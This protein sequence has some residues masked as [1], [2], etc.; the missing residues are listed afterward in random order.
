MKLNLGCHDRI[1]PGYI[2][3][4]RDKYD[5]V[6]VVAD[7]S[8]LPYKDGE[9]DEVYVSHIL[10]HFSH[11]RSLEVVKEWARVLKSGGVLKIAVPD[12]ARTI[13]LYCRTGLN[14]WIINYLYGDQIYEGAFHYCAFDESRLTRL[15]KDAGFIDIC[16]VDKLPGNQDTEC[17]NNVSNIDFKPVSLNMVAIK[18]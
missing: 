9:A 15:L 8:K 12:F 16:R 4:D 13:E 2:N 17:S 10:E 7:V 5:G 11:T 3:I 6:D 1:R 18:E 14:N